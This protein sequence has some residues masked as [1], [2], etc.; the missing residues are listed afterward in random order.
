MAACLRDM[1]YILLYITY[2]MLA[3]DVSV[4]DDGCLNGLRET[5]IALGTP[6]ASVARAVQKMK[7]FTLNLFAN[8]QDLS[9]LLSELSA[10]FDRSTASVG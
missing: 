6:T 4:L 5:Y 2:A 1:E 9:E 7:E 8:E 10:Y 3:G